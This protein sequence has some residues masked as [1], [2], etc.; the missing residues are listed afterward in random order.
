MPAFETDGVD[1]KYPEWQGPLRAA[2]LELDK[3][4]LKTLVADAEAAISARQQALAAATNGQ[5]E[6][7]ALADGL[8]LLRALKR[9]S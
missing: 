5:E 4:R 3:T 1:L 9:T 6:R 2:V 7:Q 8:S